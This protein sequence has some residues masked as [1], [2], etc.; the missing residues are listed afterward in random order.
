MISLGKIQGEP[1]EA[2]FLRAAQR[3]RL[4]QSDIREQNYP[5]LKELAFDSERKRMTT[6]HQSSG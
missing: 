4:G 2:A 1:T 6:F 5:R 3:S